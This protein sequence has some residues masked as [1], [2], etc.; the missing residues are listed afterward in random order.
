M[1]LIP[2]TNQIM[3]LGP[4]YNVNKVAKT[5]SICV[6]MFPHKVCWLIRTPSVQFRLAG[7]CSRQRL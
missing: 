5:V 6:N 4:E 3:E 2:I 7:T 1:I